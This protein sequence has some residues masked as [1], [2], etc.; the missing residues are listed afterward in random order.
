MTEN[1]HPNPINRDPW[2]ATIDAGRCVS[3]RAGRRCQL[4]TDHAIRAR[5]ADAS[6]TRQGA[7][8][9]NKACRTH[10]RQ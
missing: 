10:C 3:V 9:P 4:W 5:P 2:A 7:A 8:A 1:H 6:R